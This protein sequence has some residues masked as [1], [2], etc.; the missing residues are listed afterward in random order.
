MKFTKCSGFTLL[1]LAFACVPFAAHADDQQDNY[2]SYTYAEATAGVMSLK[3]TVTTTNGTSVTSSSET[4]SIGMIGL[5]GSYGFDKL[6]DAGKYLDVQGAGA[7]G[8]GTV[9][10]NTLDLGIVSG[11]VGAHVNFHPSLGAI[12]AFITAEEQSTSVSVAGFSNTNSNSLIIYGV[13]WMILDSYEWRF[14]GTSQGG[15]SSSSG[16][17]VGG[18]T[19][20]LQFNWV[21]HPNQPSYYIGAQYQH[22]SQSGSSSDSLFVVGGYRW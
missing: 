15:G 12:S 20:N 22:Q 19:L 13:R 7:F 14:F 6:F 5:D 18:N 17:P 8:F 21:A 10:G 1:S 11:G 2:I 4:D 9:G 3:S 16:S